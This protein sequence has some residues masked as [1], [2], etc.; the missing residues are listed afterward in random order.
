[1]VFPESVKRRM[2]R[3]ASTITERI[4]RALHGEALTNF[5]NPS[6]LL[7]WEQHIGHIHPVSYRERR[8]SI[9]WYLST[10]KTQAPEHTDISRPSND[11]TDF[12]SDAL[13]ENLVSGD[14]DNI[15]IP[16]PF[17][18]ALKPFAQYALQQLKSVDKISRD[19]EERC[20]RDAASGL[21]EDLT[22]LASLALFAHFRESGRSYDDYL[23]DLHEGSII[24][25]LSTY[26]SLARLLGEM[27]QD[28]IFG[29]K[30]LVQRLSDDENELQYFCN[31]GRSPGKVV[32][33][34]G[35]FNLAHNAFGPVRCLGFSS[36]KRIFYKPRSGETDLLYNAICDWVNKELGAL[37]LQPL[38][39]LSRENYSWQE[40]LVDIPLENAHQADDFYRRAGY[41]VALAQVLGSTDDHLENMLACGAYPVLVDNETIMGPE[42]GL[43]LGRPA[44]A[45]FA[46]TTS[47]LVGYD[48]EVSTKK[49]MPSGIFGSAYLLPR[50]E[51]VFDDTHTP[52]WRETHL[53]RKGKN[54][55]VF[56]N[57]E[58]D[59][60][61]YS[62]ALCKGYATMLQLIRD[63]RDA[64][65]DVVVEG[66]RNYS[67]AFRY[68][69]RDTPWYWNMREAL[70]RPE[71]LRSGIDRSLELEKLSAVFSGHLAN[72]ACVT[73]LQ[74]EIEHLRRMYIP[75]FYSD[76]GK[77]LSSETDG[78]LCTCTPQE[79]FKQNLKALASPHVIQEQMRILTRILRDQQESSAD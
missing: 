40:A 69:L 49:S 54:K 11:W 55:P 17:A 29:M 58:A 12:L 53:V 61:D 60:L 10:G 19:I 79:V 72:L 31:P 25:F 42:V 2:I 3:D 51:I 52:V 38:S 15:E 73:C 76:C 9:E 4:E 62:D 30:T 45:A 18:P 67:I 7:R 46:L 24:E 44:A 5:L 59:P 41:L 65:H 37:E 14:S 1:M 28:W 68:T 48:P 75:A 63:N 6:Q 16:L 34:T 27:C 21:L 13:D 78:A 70:R 56:G 66:S 26:P 74:S 23:R 64:F 8:T 33:I 32:S 57:R 35:G 43:S 77:D 50:T 47:L 36:G 71:N 20:L 39:L 22:E